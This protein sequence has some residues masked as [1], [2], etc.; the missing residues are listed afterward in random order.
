MASDPYFFAVYEMMVGVAE[1]QET[2]GIN[3]PVDFIFDHQQGISQYIQD[4]WDALKNIAPAFVVERLGR[5]P[6]FEDDKDTLP[7]QSADLFAWWARRINDDCVKNR[8]QISLFLNESPIKFLHIQIEERDIE[9]FFA[10]IATTKSVR[11][12]IT[13][14]WDGAQF[15][16]YDHWRCAVERFSLWPDQKPS[17]FPRFQA[18]ER[19]Q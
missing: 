4:A 1:Q 10:T 11:C 17:L 8:P 12:P 15:V 9:E 13:F 7:L 2:M 19:S 18:P 3:E 5:R 16:Q 14:T 6:Q